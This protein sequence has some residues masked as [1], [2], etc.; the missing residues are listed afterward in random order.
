MANK[1]PKNLIKDE[2]I[3]D[4]TQYGEFISS[5]HQWTTFE[6]QKMRTRYLENCTNKKD[7]S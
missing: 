7:K 2:S 3:E 4:T 5:F 1:D 6:N